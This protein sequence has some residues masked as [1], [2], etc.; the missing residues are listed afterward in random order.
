MP[1]TPTTTPVTVETM[2]DWQDTLLSLCDWDAGVGGTDPGTSCAIHDLADRLGEMIDA[3]PQAR[4]IDWPR[5][6]LTRFAADLRTTAGRHPE[7]KAHEV[8]DLLTM[9]TEVIDYRGPLDMSI[10]GGDPT[11]C[12]V[13]G[14]H[15]TPTFIDM[16]S[17]G[18]VDSILGNYTCPNQGRA[19]HLAVAR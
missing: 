17:G 12:P 7:G 2:H 1:S 4:F 19:D 10:T 3:E 5:Y 16:P 11:R 9:A 18:V 15:G 6:E 14:A 8:A 13:C